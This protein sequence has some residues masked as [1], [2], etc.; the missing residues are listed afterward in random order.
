MATT[1]VQR[2][3]T[4]PIVLSIPSLPNHIYVFVYCVRRCPFTACWTLFI[5]AITDSW[6]LVLWVD[7]RTVASESHF[8]VP[9]ECESAW[10]FDFTTYLVANPVS[11]STLLIF[12]VFF[13]LYESLQKARI[14]IW[15]FEQKDL[16]IEGRIIVCVFISTSAVFMLIPCPLSVFSL[17]FWTCLRTGFSMKPKSKFTWIRC[18]F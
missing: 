14:Q 16:R 1:K 2:I 5:V 8:Q 17:T 4:Q 11:I 10:A 6:L 7:A 13:F 12:L 3:M 18:W 9:P 15:L